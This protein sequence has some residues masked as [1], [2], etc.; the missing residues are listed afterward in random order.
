[1]TVA[2]IGLGAMGS[3]MA[4]RLL[5]AGHELVVWNRDAAKSEPLV[6]AGATAAETPAD[7]ARRVDVVL[8]MV[9]DPHAL[10]AVTEGPDGVAAG[11]AAGTVVVQMSTVGPGP[12]L[13]LV[14]RLP[15]GVRLLDAP[16]LGSLD[17][18]EG[19][20]LKVF[21]G[22]E[23]ELVERLRPLLSVLGSVVR[24]G[25]VGAGSAAKLVANSTLFGALGVLGEALALADALGL[26]REAA[27]DVLSATP[28]AAQAER[29]RPAV[30]SAEYPARFSLSLARKDA[31]LVLEAAADA[32]VELRLA[33]AARDWLVA[34][35][36]AGRGDEDYSAVLEQI[37]E[38]G[39]ADHGPAPPAPPTT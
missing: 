34:A 18:A 37:G 28:V 10:Q 26:T 7:A 20:K 30:E 13:R 16:V 11:A 38:S 35:E 3:R 12:V 8:I 27:F 39:G 24:V 21:A 22:G 5:D 17:E 29:R 1:V 36:Q 33:R 25:P 32:G 9:A 4:R 6:A 31:D 14:D 2:L 19:G 23:P 15:E